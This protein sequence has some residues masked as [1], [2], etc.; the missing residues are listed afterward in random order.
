M[1]PKNL[2]REH[3]VKAIQEVARVGIPEGRGSKKFLLEYNGDYYPPKYIISSANKYANGRELDPSDFSGGKETNDFLRAIGF[4][5]VG[6]SFSEKPDVKPFKKRKI[7]SSRTHHDERCPKC[8]ETVRKLLEKIYGKVEQ[9]YKFELGTH[10]DDFINTPYYAELK[11]IYEA[12]ENHRGFKEFVRAR[13]LPNCDFFVP[14]LGF[15]VEF[16]ESQ[17]FTLPRKITLGNYPE[18]LKLGFDRERCIALCDK[19]NAKD[20]HPPY[21][22][23]QRAWYDTL[24]DFLPAIIE[25]LKPT[26]RLFA[27]DFVWCSLDPNNPSNVK[28]FENILKR[29]P[30]SWELIEVRKDPDPFLTRIIIAGEWDG[31]WEDAK[32]LLEDIYKKWTKGKKV[33]FIITCGGFIQFDWPESISRRDIGDNKCP[34]S[35]AVGALVEE[36]E[37]CARLVLSGGLDKKL[38]ELTDYITLGI[39]SYKEKISTTQNYINQPHIELVFLIDLRNNESYWTG[40]SYPTSNQQNGL[41]RISDLRTHFFHLDDIGKLMILGCHDLTIYNP[42]SRNAKGWRERVN[43]EFKELARNEEPLCVLQHPHT[44]DCV[45]VWAAAWNNLRQSISSVEKYASAGR[46][47]HSGDHLYKRGKKAGEPHCTLMMVEKRTKYGDTM[48]FIVY[49]NGRHK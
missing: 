26:I 32:R 21:R 25:G 4:D 15:I 13:T 5:I 36:A 31:K 47:P 24:R 10:P 43:M 7:G 33:K 17:H 34:N 38:G 49:R 48:D 22:D 37:K 2:K 20:N 42:R 19:I 14:N 28:R 23:E 16:D 45:S 11:E 1:I 8:K 18:K 29:T 30:E 35:E 46:W 9:N 39:D 6:V 40:K 12:L 41:V 44:T 27:R 3:V